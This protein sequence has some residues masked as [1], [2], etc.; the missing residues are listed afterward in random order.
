[1]KPPSVAGLPRTMTTISCSLMVVM[2]LVVAGCTRSEEMTVDREMT[3]T[4]A[5]A[6][7]QQLELSIVD[8]FEP[9]GVVAVDQKPDGVLLNCGDE[10]YQWTGRIILT[11]GQELSVQDV[12][13]TVTSAFSEREG[14]STEVRDMQ[15]GGPTAVVSGPDGLSFV[16]GT[17][18]DSLVRVVSASRCFT[19]SEDE[20]PFSTY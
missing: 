5:K 14:F 7:T 18:A 2:A 4:Q 8:A 3:L 10:R 6:E 11:L 16:G 12:A 19:L 15:T 20:S 1:M 9:V 17:D 13:S